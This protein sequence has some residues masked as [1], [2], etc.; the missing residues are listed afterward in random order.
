VQH[1][2]N[3]SVGVVAQARRH[4]ARVVLTLH[5]YWLSCPRDGL[6]MRADLGICER[7]DHRV[8][9]TCLKDS[10]YLTPP[11]QRGLS[12]AARRAGAGRQ[13]HR[14]HAL[15]PRATQ[16]ALGILRRAWPGAGEDLAGA[17]DLRARAVRAALMNVD[18]FLA[19]TAFARERTLELGVAPG[20]VVVSRYGAVPGPTRPRQARDG[21]RRVGFVGTL[22]PH[23]GLHVLVEAFRRLD[24]PDATLD[25]HGS[26]S[27]YPGYVERVGRL[28]GEDPRIRFRGA[29]PEGEQ[30]TILEGLELLVV[31]SV[32][33]ENSPLTA[34][35]GLA[36]G[37]PVVASRIGGLPE[38]VE[39]GRSGLLVAPGDAEA[40][41][42]ALRDVVEGRLLAE[43]LEALPLKTV[44]QGALELRRV[45][46]G[47]SDTKS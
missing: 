11:L 8:C 38:I 20:Q 30:A 16:W 26:P 41:S 18:A 40:L 28:A 19:P 6:R 1:L 36:A 32:W 21:R 34:L 14:V 29:F 9:A 15:A 44:E 10:P 31:P 42:E 27:V 5:D 12:I 13:L 7:V 24:L 43:T 25:I 33:W 17:M 23:K 3:L 46:A 4:G 22:A 37:V 35:E 47:V 39:H 45:Y 2:L